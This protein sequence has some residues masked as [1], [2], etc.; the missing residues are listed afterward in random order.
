MNKLH[1]MRSSNI[2][3]HIS[4]SYR[5][6]CDSIRELSINSLGTD[7]SSF[8]NAPEMVPNH[9]ELACRATLVALQELALRQ[10][11]QET[12]FRTRV[13]LHCGEV[14]V[15]N[16]AHPNA[17]LTRSWETQS[18]WRAAWKVS[19]KVYG[20]QILASQDIPEHAGKDFESEASATGFLSPDARASLDIYEL[21]GVKSQVDRDRLHNRQLYEEALAHYFAR[22]F[23]D[24]ERLF[25][26]V[27][28]NCASDKRHS[29]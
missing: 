20:T 4:R 3:A 17:S 21:I 9:E 14:L 22:S 26:Q 18:T 29:S 24:A 25:S 16:I 1:L 12:W 7:C 8:F 13:G 15:G 23:W 2:W 28:K 6:A 11:R 10:D 19:T 27:A 5:A